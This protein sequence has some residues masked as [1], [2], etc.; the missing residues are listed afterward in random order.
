MPSAPADAKHYVGVDFGGTKIYAGV[1]TESLKCLGTARIS[2]KPNRGAEGVIERLARSVADAVDECDLDLKQV[3]G[4]GIGAPGAVDA[5][6]GRVIVAPNL[7]WQDVPLK[8]ELERHLAVPVFVENDCNLAML[9]VYAVELESKPRHALG[10]FIGTGIGGGIVINGEFYT[11][12]NHTAAE[13]GHMVLEAHNGPLC[14]CGNK[15]CFEALA[16]RTA[17]FRR[18]Q[19]AVQQGQK[20]ILAEMLG[21]S[22]EDMRSGDLRRAIRRGDKFVKKVVEDAAHYT[23]IAVANL[24]NILNPEVV[25]LGGGII[26]ALEEQ[27]MPVIKETALEHALKGT[28]TNVTI[29]AAKLADDAGIVGGAVLARK[30]SSKRPY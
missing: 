9:G 4:V 21:K 16:S 3:T 2:T 1:F 29:R 24:M 28:T 20:T 30:L 22:L 13:I 6:K 14:G 18:I 25:V 10:I 26:E 12:A 17:I 8:K 15:G 7:G 19:D 27:I 5:E 11:G 23:G